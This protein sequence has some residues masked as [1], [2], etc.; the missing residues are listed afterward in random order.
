MTGIQVQIPPT[1]PCSPDP[2]F[3]AASDHKGRLLIVSNRL[4]VS[5]K[6]K[7]DGQHDFSSSSGG[8][9]T[10]LRGLS[11]GGI[12]FL[13]YGWPGIEIED[14]NLSGL[15]TALLDEHKAVPVC[16]KQQTADDY[17]DGFSSELNPVFEVS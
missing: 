8:L 4:P 1:P 2:S 12:D 16:L 6:C 15:K 13:W 5:V 11:T 10:G 9:V 17:Y 14:G 3:E 7:G